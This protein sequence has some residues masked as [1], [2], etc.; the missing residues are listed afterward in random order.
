M[1]AIPV[2]E[3]MTSQVVSVRDDASLTNI[4]WEMTLAEIRHVPVVDER[5]RVVGIVSDR[6]L[7][8]TLP[9]M[10]RSRLPVSAVMTL[11]PHTVAVTATAREALELMLARKVHA[12]PVVDEGGALVGIVTATDFL[13]LAYRALSGLAI[14]APRTTA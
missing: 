12:L 6:D 4:D 14:D 11:S 7:L 1:R 8:R 2:S 5:G 10:D 9:R 13:D 3:I